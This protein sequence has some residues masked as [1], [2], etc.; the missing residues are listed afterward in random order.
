MLVGSQTSMLML[1]LKPGLVTVSWTS[2]NAGR[3]VAGG[4]GGCRALPVVFSAALTTVVF[5]SD[6]EARLSQLRAG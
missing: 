5:G 1:S 2:Q 6:R 4:N 3:P